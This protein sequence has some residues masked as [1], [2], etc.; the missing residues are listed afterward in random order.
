MSEQNV[1]LV[2]AALTAFRE[3][4]EEAVPELIHPDFEMTQM[5]QHPEGGGRCAAGKPLTGR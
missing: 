2:R 4:R 3:R 5:P 1:E